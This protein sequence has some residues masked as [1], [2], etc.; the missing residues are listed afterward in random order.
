MFAYFCFAG[1]IPEY[2][3]K[4]LYKSFNIKREKY[5]QSI[6]LD[7]L[8]FNTHPRNKRVI[9]VSLRSGYKLVGYSKNG[10]FAYVYLVKW[11]NGCPY[12]DLRC[13]YEYFKCKY[14]VLTKYIVKRV[15]RSLGAFK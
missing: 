10:N 7:K 3:G 15:L 5:A 1:I 12:S 11:L 4:G 8:M 2:N 13:R 6:G 9:D 14:I